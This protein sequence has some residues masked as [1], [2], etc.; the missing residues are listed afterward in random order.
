MA[1]VKEKLCRSH[2]LAKGEIPFEHR[3]TRGCLFD[4]NSI[5]ESTTNM[6]FEADPVRPMQTPRSIVV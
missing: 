5:D 1:M 2:D 6:I 4:T 3:K